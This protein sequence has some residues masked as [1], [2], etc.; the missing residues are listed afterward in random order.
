MT[1]QLFP[2]PPRRLKQPTKDVLRQHLANV[3]NENIR[4]RA[5]VERLRSVWWRR[6]I[7]RWRTAPKETP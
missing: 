4:L 3:T 5:E 1:G 2:R 7:N 6:L